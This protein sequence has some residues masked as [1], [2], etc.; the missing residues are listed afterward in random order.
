MAEDA[1]HRCG[2]CL[3]AESVTGMPLTI[4]PSAL[5]ECGELLQKLAVD[6]RVAAVLFALRRGLAP[7]DRDRPA[8]SGPRSRSPGQI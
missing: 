4:E 8:G 2:Y 5:S 6:T 1:G 7:L 3:G